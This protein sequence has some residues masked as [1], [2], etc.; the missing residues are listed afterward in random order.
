VADAEDPRKRRSDG[1][2]LDGRADLSNPCFHLLALG[3][4]PV[5]LR[6]RDDALVQQALHPVEVEARKIALRLDGGQLGP[7]LPR[8]ELRQYLPCTNRP[9]GIERDAID[10]AGKVRAHGDTLH[11]GHRPDRAQRGWPRLLLRHDC[12][13]RFRRWLKR[14]PLRDRCLDLLEFHEAQTGDEQHRHGQHHDHPF[15]HNLLPRQLSSLD[16][17]VIES[18]V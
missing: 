11:G 6:P 8:V 1:F 5:V 9:A 12:R 4:R 14:C 15:R 10:R 16:S 17:Q 7:L 2:P 13:D 3:G 18:S